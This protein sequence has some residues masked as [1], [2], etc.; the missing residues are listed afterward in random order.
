MADPAKSDMTKRELRNIFNMRVKK[1]ATMKEISLINHEMKRVVVKTNQ[2]QNE[3]PMIRYD[4]L[5]S[6]IISSA[7]Q[8]LLTLDIR[9]SD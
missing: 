5:K 4:K 6:S 2:Q 9:G 7:E 3:M 8:F 1:L